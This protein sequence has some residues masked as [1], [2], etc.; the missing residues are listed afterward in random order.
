MP[1]NPEPIPMGNDKPSNNTNNS[2]VNITDNTT[3]NNSS[4]L[5]GPGANLGNNKNK[6]SNVSLVAP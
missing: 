3:T 5:V 2:T 6:E 4:N 1:A